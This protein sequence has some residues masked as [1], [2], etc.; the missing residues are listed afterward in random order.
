MFGIIHFEVFLISALLLNL[1]PG[2]DTMYIISR[3]VTQGKRAGIYS[4][5]GITSG[6][7][8]HTILASLGLTVILMKSV[9]LFTIIKIIGALYLIYLGVNLLINK[10]TNHEEQIASKYMSNK[11]IYLQGLITNVTN[12]KVAL[13]FLAFIPQFISTGNS[14]PL[15][16]MILGLTFCVTGGLWC[17]I[18]AL[19]SSLLTKK[20]RQ[21]SKIE[22]ILNKLTGIIFIA[23]GIKLFKTKAA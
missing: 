3:S 13:F 10:K 12:P 9:L 1:T 16:F 11:K 20:L 2:N 23:M 22:Q 19:F 4:A 18:V 17:V 21:S 7:V 5:L 15:P 6:A 14:S 8:V